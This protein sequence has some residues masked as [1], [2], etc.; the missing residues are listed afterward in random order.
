VWR[1]DPRALPA[2]LLA[3]A[4][5]AGCTGNMYDQPKVKPLAAND[6][7]QDSRGSR[8]PPAGTVARE[9][10]VPDAP[11]TTGRAP[12]P[13]GTP[14]RPV[15]EIPLPVTPELL[16]RGR[17][18]FDIY[19]SVCHGR[20]GDGNGMIPQR[21]F[22]KPP[23]YHG[24]RLRSAPAGH[25]FEVAT[26]GFGAMRGYADRVGVHDRWAIVAYIRALQLSQAAPAAQLPEAL[27][28]RLEQGNDAAR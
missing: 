20:V 6:F 15:D 1:P 5:A 7:F 27:R 22:Q 19:C 2:L 12:G 13:P 11:E 8:E 18:R 14:A 23:S 16:A 28:Q 21:G 26:N 25:F 10:A 24:D 4:A 9:D 3:A 17:E